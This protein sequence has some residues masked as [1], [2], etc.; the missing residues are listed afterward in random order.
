M[1]TDWLGVSFH[2]AT[3]V[4]NFETKLIS[5]ASE[6]F[7]EEQSALEEM[8]EYIAD[9]QGD[10]FAIVTCRYNFWFKLKE[11]QFYV[12][13]MPSMVC[14]NMMWSFKYS[15]LAFTAMKSPVATV[16]VIV[17]EVLPAPL[18][19]S[20]KVMGLPCWCHKHR[21]AVLCE[22]SIS[23]HCANDDFMPLV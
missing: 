3:N 13:Y 4:Y 8:V 1:K 14:I 17:T 20:Y 5:L 16:V 2:Y 15:V 9:D 22:F 18:V 10:Y 21:N 11:W 19:L 6:K 7:K 23:F 12:L